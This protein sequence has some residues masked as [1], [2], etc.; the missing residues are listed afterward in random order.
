MITAITA[1]ELLTPAERISSPVVLV[2]DGVISR[3]GSKQSVEI[4]TNAALLDFPGSV[5]TPGFM[6]I[7]IHGSA[8]YDVMQ[9]DQKGLEKMASFLAH[10]GVTSFLATTVT[11]ERSAL[12]AAVERLA[13]QIHHWPSDS[14]M[15]TPFGI[16]ME[17]PW[18]S[19][20]RCGVHPTAAIENPSLEMFDRYHRAANGC[21][22]LVTIAPE[23]PGANDV[24]REAVKRGVR[25]SLGHTDGQLSDADA[26]I[27]SGA[28][29][30]THTFNAMRPLNHRLPGVLGRVLDDNAVSAEIIADGIHVDPVVVDLF[31]R[32]KGEDQSVLVTDATSA[33]GM[34]DGKYKLGTFEVTV[35]GDRCELNGKLAGSVL[36][37]DRAVR[38]VMQYSGWTLGQSVRLATANPARVIGESGRGTIHPGKRADITVLSPKGE[39]I[40]CFAAGRPT[41]AASGNRAVG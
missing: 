30:A 18:I 41:I 32:C 38:N 15:A 33:A 24:I 11:A 26:A 17:G 19:K 35:T 8:G 23:L 34:P 27:Q 6:D 22:R 25:V 36:T 7:H 12:V 20:L 29:H 10:R 4:P 37:L 3:F 40:E 21:L 5:L 2:E 16:H 28:T 13:E 14:P 39:V 9:G 1:A 31:L